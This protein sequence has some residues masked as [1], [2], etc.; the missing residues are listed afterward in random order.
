MTVSGNYGL[1]QKNI[2][3]LK[4]HRFLLIALIVGLTLLALS[5]V[6]VTLFPW[7]NVALSIVIGGSFIYK[8]LKHRAADIK[9]IDNGLCTPGII[10]DK[11]C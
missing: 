1:N 2:S 9:L 5:V 6:F 3:W 4:K 7:F 10:I 8:E 11:N